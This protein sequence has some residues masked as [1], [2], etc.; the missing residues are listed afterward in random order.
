MRWKDKRVHVLDFEGAPRTGVIEYGVVTL[1]EGSLESTGTRLCGAREEL[2]IEDMRVHGIEEEMIADEEPFE[3]D[4]DQFSYIRSTGLMAAHHA[5]VENNLLK[6][7]WPYPRLTDSHRQFGWGPWIDTRR[8][9]AKLYKGLESYSL[10]SLIDTFALVDRLGEWA[11]QHCP[12]GRGKA[13]C[14]LYDALAAALLLVR[15]DEMPE[16]SDTTIDWLLEVSAP[17]QRRRDDLRQ[18]DLFSG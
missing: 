15:L 12:P 6:G 18:G 1:H 13:H 11:K 16:L 2:K 7:T 4:W 9:Y 3:T 17:D 8:V 14:A 5:S 10:G